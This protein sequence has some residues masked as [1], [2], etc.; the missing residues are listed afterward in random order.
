[1]K[2]EPCFGD[3]VKVDTGCQAVFLLTGSIRISDENSISSRQKMAGEAIDGVTAHT[4]AKMEVPRFLE[5][6]DTV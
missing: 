5:H 4:Q 3:N 6:P 2:D 1:M